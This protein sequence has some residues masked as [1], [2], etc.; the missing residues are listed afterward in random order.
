[1]TVA[2]IAGARQN[3]LIT[4]NK[5]ATNRS[6][7]QWQSM[8]FDNLDASW[9]QV[10]PAI[11]T[12]VVSAQITSAAGSDRYIGGVSGE[13]GFDQ[14]PSRIVPEMFAGVDGSGRSVDTLL[15]GAVTTTKEAIGRGLGRQ[16]LEAGAAYLASMIKT[17]LADSGRSADMVS[18]T[19]KGYTHYVRVISPGA[20]RR[21]AILA[22]VSDYKK[23]FKRHPACKCTSAP[24]DGDPPAGLFGSADE[25]FASL[26]KADQ[27]RIFTNS[28]AQAIR[29]GASIQDIVDARRGGSGI[30]TSHGIGHGT[31]LNSGR[32][33]EKS[34]IGYRADGTPITAYTTSEGT[35]VRGSFGAA[36]KRLDVATQ[37]LGGARYSST[38]RV[39]L[40]PESIYEIAASPA[41]ARV[42]LR[43]AGY[44]HTP[45]LTAAQ[46][47]Q[48]AMTDRR[49]ANAIYRRAGYSL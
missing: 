44:M 47:A 35:T 10:A 2:E 43:D 37:R 29:D 45:G 42:L 25:Y 4:I 36:Q 13:Y 6:L 31:F 15:H 28:G 19:G 12:Q 1:M 32:R 24:V 39:R 49:L 8:D 7:S 27:D 48:Q 5:T 16:S 11:M 33:L 20:C 46:E 23:A 41:E 22:G 17:V 26:S 14:D 38:S 3:R 30:T 40:M 21:C 34:I 18:A 9:A